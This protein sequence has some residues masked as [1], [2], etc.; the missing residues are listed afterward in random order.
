MDFNTSEISQFRTIIESIVDTRIKRKRITSFVSAVVLNVDENGYVTV[1]IPPEDQKP[2]T[3]LLNKTGEVL[4]TG[5]SVELA[6]KNGT[7]SN[8]WVAVKHGTNNS[9]GGG[10]G[11]SDYNA[12][13]N[14][15][16]LNT[17][18]TTALPTNNNETI[19]GLVDL[20]QI[21]K[22]G[23]YNDLLNKP[24]IPQNAKDIYIVPNQS[25]RNKAVA[26]TSVVILDATICPYNISMGSYIGGVYSAGIPTIGSWNNT[27]V[28]DGLGNIANLADV[29]E[30][31]TKRPLMRN[32]RPVKA[33]IQ[34]QE[35]TPDGSPINAN[36]QA[37]F[38]TLFDN[39]PVQIN[40]TDT[41]YISFPILYSLSNRPDLIFHGAVNSGGSSDFSVDNLTLEEVGGVV[42]IKNSDTAQEGGIYQMRNGQFVFA[43]MDGGTFD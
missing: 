17:T 27:V 40:I 32:G 42:R 33:L 16:R 23:N 36:L 37:S 35:L 9:G 21:S 11:T 31:A 7:L 5:D 41:I 12:L 38:V 8:S 28:R 2:I 10:S 39:A 20:H 6:T 3:N 13:N 43:D 34:A 14:R 4:H 15:P 1:F 18:N 19:Q 29:F 22:T 30:Y 24:V 26:N 25:F